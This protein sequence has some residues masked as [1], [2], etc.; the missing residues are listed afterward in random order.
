MVASGA[1][2]EAVAAIKI[3][4]AIVASHPIIP[5]PTIQRIVSRP[6]YYGVVAVFPVQRVDI[7]LAKEDVVPRA[8]QERVIARPT[9]EHVVSPQPRDGI[10]ATET[11]YHVI[12]RGPVYDVIALSPDMGDV[13]TLTHTGLVHEDIGQHV[14]VAEH[15][16]GLYGLKRDNT[17]VGADGGGVAA[18]ANAAVTLNAA[19]GDAEPR[20]GPPRTVMHEDVRYSVGIPGHKRVGIGAKDDK[21][22]FATDGRIVALA[23]DFQTR[24]IDADSRSGPCLAVMHE[25]VPIVVTIPG[26]EIGGS[27]L[28][29]NKA[30]SA[31]E[32]WEAA[33]AVPCDA[34]RTDADSR[35]GPE[36]T[37]TDEDIKSAVAVPRR[38][39]AVT[40]YGLW[41][42]W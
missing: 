11:D 19:G 14:G 28:K 24:R 15:K 22:S 5:L 16:I 4:I 6:T 33:R 26:H 10:I 21:P 25:D 36:H 40:W 12:A 30:P 31:A 42:L 9:T 3:V 7:P 34:Y 38:R 8:A 39:M 23:I 17:H 1:V 18:A 13:K 41:G 32:R 37:V 2:V 35:D 20:G 29:R 27:R